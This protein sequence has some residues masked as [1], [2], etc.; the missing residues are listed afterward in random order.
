M[1]KKIIKYSAE[2]CSP[3]RQFAPIFEEVSKM[4]EYSSI[5]FEEK[6]VDNCD[7]K[8]TEQYQ[9]RNIPTLVF[10]DENNI[11]TKKIVGGLSKTQFVKLIND[12]LKDEQ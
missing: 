6:D 10:L 8:E 11:L 4:E 2:W 7:V 5:E 12:E 1:I 3:C 9:V